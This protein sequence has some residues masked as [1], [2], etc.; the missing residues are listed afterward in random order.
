MS[1]LC[2]GIVNEL[3]T[4]S[5][6]KHGENF[7]LD[8]YLTRLC[9]AVPRVL[10]KLSP[11]LDAEGERDMLV[12]LEAFTVL[13]HSLRQQIVGHPQFCYWWA[14]LREHCR[15]NDHDLIR[16]W[17]RHFHRMLVPG[18]AEQ[19][20]FEDLWLSICL[21]DHQIRFPSIACRWHV[22]EEDVGEM[23]KARVTRT[24]LVTSD[25]HFLPLDCTGTSAF[26]PE[27]L[28][29]IA[30]GDILVDASDPWITRMLSSLNSKPAPA[31]YPPRDYVPIAK[32]DRKLVCH[33]SAAFA[34]LQK[35]DPAAAEEFRTHTRQIVPYK[36]KYYSTFTETAFS[37]AVFVSEAYK[38]FDNVLDTVE[39]LYHEHSHF[40]LALMLEF[41]PL[42]RDD[43]RTYFSP[44]RRVSR[45]LDGMLQAIYVFAR[46]AKFLRMVEEVEPSEQC[47]ARRKAVVSDLKAGIEAL[48][49]GAA[50]QFTPS[51]ERFFDEIRSEAAT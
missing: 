15:K 42:V 33:F 21:C 5:P 28:A 30:E 17:L 39:H 23:L 46:I 6:P 7:V 44:W 9:E 25:G 12:G 11:V 8:A 29:S 41:D 19:G 27:R 32:P 4:I 1:L 3:R 50:L 34:L 14:T 20:G 35:V 10:K 31:G 45:D 49:S 37:G 24:H 43:G 51:G 40:R 48:D 2:D 26:C 16:Y 38:P 13:S 18:L 47:R 36:S 22:P